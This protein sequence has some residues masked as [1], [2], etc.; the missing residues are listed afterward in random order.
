M[1]HCP[2]CTGSMPTNDPNDADY[3]A[4]GEVVCGPVCHAK[5]YELQT[6]PDPHLKPQ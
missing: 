3:V 4:L 5:M 6:C 2:V 1:F